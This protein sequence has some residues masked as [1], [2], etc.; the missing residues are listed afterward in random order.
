MIKKS[1]IFEVYQDHRRKLYTVN[2]VPNESVYGEKLI[3]QYREWDPN[4]SKLASLILKGSPNIFIRKNDVIL[5]LGA[6]TGTTVSHIS[7]IVGIKGFIFAVDLS[8]FVLRELTF[9]SYKRNNIAPILLDASSSKLAQRISQVDVIY[10]DI[11]QK[12]QVSIFLK[13]VDLF[14]KK[15]GYAILALKS[16]SIDVTKRPKDI[17]NQVKE[18]LSEKLTIIDYRTLDPFQKDHCMFICK[19]VKS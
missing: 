8:P 16:R 10:Q 18:E 13:N 4:K 6:S 7:D 11:A 17:Y 19:N 12:D 5:Y 2:L 14:L 1:N 15:N 9:L 3:D